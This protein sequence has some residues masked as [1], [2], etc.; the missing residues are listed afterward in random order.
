MTPPRTT[1]PRGAGLRPFLAVP[2][3]VV[4]VWAEWDE[5]AVLCG[6]ANRPLCRLYGSFLLAS[7]SVTVVLAGN[8]LDQIDDA[9]PQFG[10][11]D[12]HE[13][14]G[15]REPLRCGEKIRYKGR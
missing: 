8:L 7:S 5:R 10:F 1:K 13:R 3:G 9:A 2:P 4:K 11:L 12:P 15:Q 6:T 14:L